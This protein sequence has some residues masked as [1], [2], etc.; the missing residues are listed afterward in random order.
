[1]RQQL[2]LNNGNIG[3]MT[4]DM[5]KLASPMLYNYT[6]DQLNRIVGMDAWQSGDASFGSITKLQDYAERYGYD[7]NG[8]ILS[9]HRNGTTSGGT[10]LGMDNLSYK[11]VY[12]KTAASGGGLGS[13]FLDKL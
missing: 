6:Y 12:A 13:M 1:M 3:S 8:N 5:G 9:L 2:P 11:Y 10:L 7:P 4:V